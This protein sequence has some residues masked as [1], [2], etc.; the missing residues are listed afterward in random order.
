MIVDFG[1]ASFEKGESI[2]QWK[3]AKNS[4]ALSSDDISECIASRSLHFRVL[5]ALAHI[6]QI[7]KLY[8]A[9]S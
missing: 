3:K 5:Q 4:Y 7:A 2:W 6:T 1:C 8:Q 9:N